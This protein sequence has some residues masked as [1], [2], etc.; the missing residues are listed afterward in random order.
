MTDPVGRPTN[1]AHAFVQVHV[2]P[3]LAGSSG[4]LGLAQEFSAQV[5]V[6]SDLQS[7]AAYASA[8]AAEEPYISVSF[9]NPFDLSALREVISVEPA[10]NISIS[11]DY[12]N[13]AG[14]RGG[15][16][17]ATRYAIKIAKTPAHSGTRRYPAS[18]TLS[19][20]IPDRTPGVWLEHAEGYLSSA[21]NR[22]VKAHA[23]N[24]QDLKV[25]VSRVYENN[26]VVWRNA[27]SQRLW[28][29][30]DPYGR[31]LVDRQIHLPLEKNKVQDISLAIDDLL[32][33]DVMRDG[34]YQID[35]SSR[36][37]DAGRVRDIGADGRDEDDYSA[38]HASSMVTLSD[39]GIT[40]KQGRTGVNIWATSLRTAKP[41]QNVRMRLYSNKNQPIGQAVTNADGLARIAKSQTG[42]GETASVILADLRRRKEPNRPAASP[43]SIS[44]PVQSLSP[45]M[46]PPAAPISVAATKRSF[47]LIAAFIVQVKRFI[48]CAIIRGADNAMPTGQFP[49]RWQIRRPD[50]RNWKRRPRRST[51][52][53]PRHLIFNCR[54]ISPPANGAPM[55]ACPIAARRRGCSARS[56]SRWKNSYPIR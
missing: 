21:G 33:A 16:R 43:G 1:R 54:P 36:T 37:T 7:E 5:A 22:T 48:S 9:N 23:V 47:T 27:S 10:A 29:A 41:L 13:S 19:V 50:L 53:A 12:G 40:A 14:L 8:P 56:F 35:I 30:L 3:G 42:P 34:V 24:V 32:P 52:M 46:I 17:P 38:L 45:T 11:S 28:R 49:V 26:I 2:S 39:I 4:P 44:A 18:T 31:P 6:T 25:S 20:F 15:L 51:P 55:S